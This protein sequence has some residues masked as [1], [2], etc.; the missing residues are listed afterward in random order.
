MPAAKSTNKPLT[1]LRLRNLKPGKTVSDTEENRG[2]RVTRNKTGLRY[3]Y[4]FKHPGTG[5]LA[6][7]TLF[8]KDDKALA[9]ARVV[10]RDL[11]TQRANGGVPELP[12]DYRRKPLLVEEPQ[13]SS[14]ST[15]KDLVVTYLKDHV[16]KKLTLG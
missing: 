4:R 2:L 6:E 8:T 1:A 10:F 3:W 5:K 14:E 9:E 15:V 12:T 16:Y 13:L 7:L 11:K